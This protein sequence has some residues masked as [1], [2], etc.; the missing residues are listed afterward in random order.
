VFLWFFCCHLIYNIFEEEGLEFWL[1][2]F[3]VDFNLKFYK[4]IIVKWCICSINFS[5]VILL[6]Q[7]SPVKLLF[8][9]PP[10]QPAFRLR[11]DH[12]S[13]N[14]P[15][16]LRTNRSFYKRY[17]YC[18]KNWIKFKMKLINFSFKNI[19]CLR[20]NNNQEFKLMTISLENQ[21]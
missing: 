13:T 16:T 19:T 7:N 15:D 18:Y 17:Y 21:I 20:L 8:P 14:L 2:N 12:I 10:I 9:Y 5:L 11:L 1:S 4:A 6:L 3:W